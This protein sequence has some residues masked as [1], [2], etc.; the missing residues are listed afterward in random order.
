[1]QQ[2]FY[3]ILK[4]SKRLLFLLLLGVSLSFVIQSHTLHRSKLI[5]SA[6]L[7]IGGTY[8]VVNTFDRYLNLKK[9]NE[10]LILEN[11][12]LKDV[13]F[14]VIDQRGIT[15]VDSLLNNSRFTVISSRIIN[16]SYHRQKNFLTINSGSKDGLKQDMGVINDKGIVGIVE[17]TSTNYATIISILNTEIKVNAKLRHS[18]HFGELTWN[19]KDIEY[20][21]LI[22]FPRLATFQKGDTIV[23]GEKSIIFPGDIPIG[24]INK[25]YIDHRTNN[26]TLDIR[27]FND[28]TNLSDVQII[29]INDKEEIID[30]EKT[31]EKE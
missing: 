20:V 7:I 22:D 13:L 24:T 15:N 18:N 8:D 9:E 28:M 30:L 21:Q 6:N 14:N 26:Y 4:N 3:F 12:K 10:R 19:G 31:I 25:V 11:T 23:T 5:T 2:I 1:M 27:L 17:N 16:N 29:R